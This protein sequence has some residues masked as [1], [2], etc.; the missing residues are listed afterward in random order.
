VTQ[1]LLN[2]S[3]QGTKSNGCNLEM[4]PSSSSPQT[5]SKLGIE[6]SEGRRNAG[7]RRPT[8]PNEREQD[9]NGPPKGK[10]WAKAGEEQPTN[11]RLACRHS[12]RPLRV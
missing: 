3:G 4:L 9:A 2:E 10:V 7:D 12:R 5:M 1:V 11:A 6:P 8:L